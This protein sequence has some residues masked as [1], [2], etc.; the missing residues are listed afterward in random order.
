M[1]NHHFGLGILNHRRKEGRPHF[2][3]SHRTL[4]LNSVRSDDR[5]RRN[6]ASFNDCQVEVMKTD[7][8]YVIVPTS[9]NVYIDLLSK[10][11]LYYARI[12]SNNKSTQMLTNAIL[13]Y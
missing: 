3:L 7:H 8:S 12:E 13:L 4:S 1:L 11:G 2:W 6:T 10:F 5:D 9:E